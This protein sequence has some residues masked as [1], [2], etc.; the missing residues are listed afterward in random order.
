[1]PCTAAAYDD[2]TMETDHVIVGHV[3]LTSL[4]PE[5]GHSFPGHLLNGGSH[6]RKWAGYET[7]VVDCYLWRMGW[8]VHWVCHG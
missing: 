1:M 6:L 3:I 5:C 4:H 8:M 7:I 2:Y